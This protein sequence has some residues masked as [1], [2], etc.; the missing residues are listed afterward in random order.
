MFEYDGVKSG[1]CYSGRLVKHEPKYVNGFCQL[2]DHHPVIVSKSLT[3]NSRTV[4][5]K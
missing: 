1:Q 4:E 2:Q 5:L 3:G